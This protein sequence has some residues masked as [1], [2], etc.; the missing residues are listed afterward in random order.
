MILITLKR[1]CMNHYAAAGRQIV[2]CLKNLLL[3]KQV[4]GCPVIGNKI[5]GLPKSVGISEIEV[6]IEWLRSKSLVHVYR[7]IFGAT[8]PL[9]KIR[10]SMN[11]LCIGESEFTTYCVLRCSPVRGKILTT[12]FQYPGGSWENLRVEDEAGKPDCMRTDSHIFFRL[13]DRPAMVAG[14]C[15]CCCVS[16]R[17]AI[18]RGCICVFLQLPFAPYFAGS[19]CVLAYGLT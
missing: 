3:V 14:Y 16:V 4:L 5:K 18:A 12:K 17:L 8:K 9:I 13:V 11:G 1:Q 15:V 7:D 10:R 6:K 19:A 2:N